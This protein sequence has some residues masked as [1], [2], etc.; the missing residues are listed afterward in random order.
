[1]KNKVFKSVL[2][3]ILLLISNLRVSEAQILRVP[4]DH[5]TIQAAIDAAQN[6]DTILVSPGEYIENLNMKGKGILL[7]SWFET[8]RDMDYITQTIING[9]QP[10]YEDTASCILIVSS[11]DRNCIVSGF[12][13]TGGRGTKWEDEHNRGYWYTEGGGILIQAAS[14]TIKN[15]IIR[16][17]EALN[18]KG[19]IVSAGGGAIRMGDSNPLIINNYISHNKG[20][21]GAG[22]V[23]NYSGAVI[24]NN[25]IVNNTGGQDY[26]GGG[27]WILEKAS[28]LKII[29]NNTILNNSGGTAGGGVQL[30]NASAIFTNNII[31]GNHARTGAQVNGSSTFTY[32]NIEG[33]RTGE[34][35]FDEALR[36]TD[37]SYIIPSG[38]QSIDGGNPHA[39]YNDPEDPD[40]AGSPL[41]PSQG[42]LRNDVGAHGG[43]G[44]MNFPEFDTSTASW[45]DFD[46]NS[47]P[48][49]F[50]N[51]AINQF[52]VV[53]PDSQIQFSKFEVIN[54]LGQCLYRQSIEPNEKVVYLSCT[55]IGLSSGTYLVRIVGRNM[56]ISNRLIV[57]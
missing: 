30:L 33:G 42:T 27:L 21:Y 25:I 9:S 54:F 43:P 38:S 5:S 34:G 12:T 15:N 4:D 17:N 47:Q 31:R 3:S 50:P 53:L 8:T 37:P 57:L 29:E 20:R 1:M 32:C 36:F 56:A 52:Q 13:I 26:G 55:N 24:R 40:Q 39:S 44:A 35:N 19:A 2:F 51:P 6:G 45:I 7:A 49:L 16:D 11:E 10:Q 46:T 22:I 14:P 23:L 48:V 41:A 18:R 28:D